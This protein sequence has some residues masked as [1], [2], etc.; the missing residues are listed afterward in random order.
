MLPSALGT[1][2]LGFPICMKIRKKEEE[3]KGKMGGGEGGGGGENDC[4]GINK[5]ILY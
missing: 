3:E 1:K 2:E 4:T 5:I